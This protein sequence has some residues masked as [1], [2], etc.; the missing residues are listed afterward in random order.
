MP[1]DRTISPDQALRR[2]LDVIAD[3]AA[4]N[5]AFRNRL[6]LA[7]GTTI[8]FEGEDDVSTMRPQDLARLYDEEKFRR[9]YGRFNAAALRRILITNELATTTDTRSVRAPA[10]LDML[11][12]RAS[13]Q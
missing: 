5:A 9:I 7:L 3:Q 4:E 1:D 10:L 13:A 6:I 2:F 8:Y 12:A 11:W